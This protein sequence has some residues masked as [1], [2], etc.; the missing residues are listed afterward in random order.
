MYNVYGYSVDSSKFGYTPY[1]SKSGGVWYTSVYQAVTFL[2]ISY[3]IDGFGSTDV[4]IS[5]P[6]DWFPE[7]RSLLFGCSSER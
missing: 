7:M 4:P 5:W 1:S 3:Y 2:C 6:L